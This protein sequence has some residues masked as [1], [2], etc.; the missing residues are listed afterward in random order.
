MQDPFNLVLAFLLR[1][2]VQELFLNQCGHTEE[3]ILGLGLLHVANG[4][5]LSILACPWRVNNLCS[6]GKT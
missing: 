6:E 4:K 1:E 3:E 2:F 5:W